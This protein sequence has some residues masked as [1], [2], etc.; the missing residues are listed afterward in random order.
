M[1]DHDPDVAV[2][3]VDDDVDWV[4]TTGAALEGAHDALSVV[5]ATGGWEALDVIAS[6]DFDCVV[7]DYRM[8]DFDGIAL[9]ERIRADYGDVPF[10]LVTGAGSEAVASRAI[11]SRVTDYF[12]KEPGRD[13]SGTLGMRIRTAVEAYRARRELEAARRRFTGLFERVPDPVAVVDGSGG[14]REV[15]DAFADVFGVGSVD[16]PGWTP[17]GPIGRVVD[18]SW[19]RADAAEVQHLSTETE[20]GRREFVVRRFPLGGDEA[21]EFGVVFT[22]VTRHRERERELERFYELGAEVRELLLSAASREELKSGICETVVDS[23]GDAGAFLLEPEDGRLRTVAS[24]GDLDEGVEAA[25]SDPDEEPGS[26]DGHPH[27]VAGALGDGEPKH[28]ADLADARGT[29]ADAL[30]SGGVREVLAAP[31]ERDGIPAGVFVVG[32]GSPGSLRGEHG[33]RL[34]ELVASLGDAMNLVDRAAAL[35]AERVVRVRLAVED[36]GTLLNALSRATGVPFEAV[37]EVPRDDGTSLYVQFDRGDPERLRADIQTVGEVAD[38]VVVAEG[39]RP[40]LRVD[41]ASPALP[42]TLAGQ[43]AA[44]DAVRVDGGRTTASVDVPLSADVGEA[45]AAVE[46]D[47]DAVDVH[48]IRTVDRSPDEAADAL[49]LRGLTEKQRRAL[50]AA[51]HE[52][53]FER[54]RARSAD[55]VS[56]TLG[57]SRSTFLQHLRAAERKLLANVL[58]SGDA[59]RRE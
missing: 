29:W 53:Y 48:S 25:L 17:D 28:V 36:A 50:R 38:A 7:C 26:N 2:L 3:L 9:L 42:T 12:V 45:V 33:D 8:P 39:E 47:Y 58:E 24:A 11:S 46:A 14:I 44:P 55:D 23:V 43:A 54:P 30:R 59:A 6:E 13:Q 31:V 40:R 41:A 51:Y 4:E 19:G 15:N 21:D 20:R 32:T 16:D 56:A 34:V 49:P 1:D 37:A 5:T 10:I 22:D 52:G 27:P 18:G 35:T 57:V